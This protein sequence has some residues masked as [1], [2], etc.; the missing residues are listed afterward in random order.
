TTI[1]NILSKNNYKNT[2]DKLQNRNNLRI[3]DINENYFEKIDSSDKAYFLGFLVADGYNSGAYITFCLGETDTE[4]IEIF[5]DRLNYSGKLIRKESKII[6]IKEKEYIRKPQ[7]CLN[8]ACKKLC[9]DL[10]K[11]G[12]IPAKTNKT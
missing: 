10:I 9:S 5:K 7:T 1:W 12:V 3:Y 2:I 8:I 11:L 6:V 4:I